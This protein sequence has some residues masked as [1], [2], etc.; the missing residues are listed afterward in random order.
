LL[1]SKVNSITLDS[2]GGGL[3]LNTSNGELPLNAVRRVL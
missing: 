3:I 2:A 1:Q